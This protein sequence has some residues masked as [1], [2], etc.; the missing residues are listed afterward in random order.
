LRIM[1]LYPQSTLPAVVQ[2][3]RIVAKTFV[4]ETPRFEKSDFAIKSGLG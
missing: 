2:S 4:F 1:D 3:W